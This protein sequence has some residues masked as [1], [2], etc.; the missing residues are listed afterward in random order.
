MTDNKKRLKDDISL[1]L[2]FKMVFH[3]KAD[4]LEMADRNKMVVDKMD[5]VAD[6]GML[7]RRLKSHLTIHQQTEQLTISFDFDAGL[8]IRALGLPP[9]LSSLLI[10]YASSDFLE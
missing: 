5:M 1:L 2:L 8:C 4:M 3:N 10:S 7:M 9:F 6:A